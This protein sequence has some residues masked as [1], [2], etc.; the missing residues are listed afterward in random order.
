MDPVTPANG[1]FDFF[2]ANL[3]P[4][5]ETPV[6]CSFAYWVD[7][8]AVLGTAFT[9]DVNYVDPTGQTR[10]ESGSPISLADSTGFFR[11]PLF[12]I[13][14]LSA[15]SVVEVVRTLIGVASTSKVAARISFSNDGYECSQFTG[16]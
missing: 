9:M 2:S 6:W 16:W 5:F 15:T 4:D 7:V 10:T 8:A 1:T 12:S 11:S 3:T 13:Q 14:R